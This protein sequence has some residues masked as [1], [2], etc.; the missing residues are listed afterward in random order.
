M[1]SWDYV[2]TDKDN[3]FTRIELE[4]IFGACEEKTLGFLDRMNVFA[5]AIKSPK[6]TGIAGNVVE[7][8]VLGMKANSRQEPDLDVEGELVELKTT[9]VRTDKNKST[10]YDAKEPVT[11]TAVSID[12]IVKEESFDSSALW[13]KLQRIL[14]VYYHYSSNVTVKALGYKDFKVLSYQFYAPSELDKARYESDWTIVRDYLRMVQDTYDNP[15][16]G[17]P[18]LSTNINPTLVVMD[19]SPKYRNEPGHKSQPRFRIRRAYFTLI[20][21][22]HFA[23]KKTKL[24][25][26]DK[27]YVS[28]AEL[29]SKLHSIADR[30]INMNVEKIAKTFNITGK[31]DKRIAEK[32]IVAMFGGK[33]KKLS[34]VELFQAFN[35]DGFS[36]ALSKNGGRTEDTKMCSIDFDEVMDDK[37]FEESD[38]FNYYHDKTFLCFILKETQVASKA[39][40]REQ[41]VEYAKNEFLGFKRVHFSDEFIYENVKPVWDKIRELISTKT[42][43]FI[44]DLDKNGNPKRNETGVIKG[45][46]NFPKSSEGCIFVRGTGNDSTDKPVTVNGIDMYH[47][48]LWISGTKIVDILSKIDFI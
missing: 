40:G 27:D 20:V 8:S 1:P 42:L 14:F 38:F 5:R 16:E 36:I 43:R 22:R 32:L 41:K 45:A 28:F 25:Q 18:L 15:E 6:I 13:H 35:V 26:L 24:E 12:T 2:K 30:Y 21:K 10:E 29:D 3:Q 23:S 44:P 34:K 31:I 7:Q 9:G 47:Q 33:S 46:P 4:Y 48:N 17:Y 11:I 39:K 37:P 19:T